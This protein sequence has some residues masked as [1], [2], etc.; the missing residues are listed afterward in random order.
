MEDGSVSICLVEVQFTPSACPLSVQLRNPTSNLC[1][2][3]YGNRE[4]GEVGLY[5]CHGEGGPQVGEGVMVGW[6]RVLSFLLN[7]SFK[8]D[9]GFTNIGEIMFDDDLCLG[10]DSSVPGSPMKIMG[11]DDGDVTQK[12]KYSNKVEL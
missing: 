4:G 11:C 5:T 2:D 7:S 6:R 9:F 1:I 12:W 8:Q 10:M 3:T